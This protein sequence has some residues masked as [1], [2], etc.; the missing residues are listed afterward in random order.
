MDIWEGVVVSNN[1]PNKTKRV[2]VRIFGIHDESVADEDL[3][4]ALPV[5]PFGFGYDG[6]SGPIGVPTV[7]TSLLLVFSQGDL[8]NPIYLGAISHSGVL[9]PQEQDN[10]PNRVGFTVGSTEFLLDRDG[11][12]TVKHGGTTVT[13]GTD[14]SVT[15][16][17]SGDIN[18]TSSGTV[19]VQAV[20]INLN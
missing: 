15:V 3:P 2:R 10:Y 6:T 14:G 8:A 16:A 9:T 7:G 12:L 13:V 20:K 19:N 18:V 1:D 4:W 17:A 11:P 5:C